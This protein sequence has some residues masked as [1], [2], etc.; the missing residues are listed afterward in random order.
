[1][2]W[3]VNLT[4]TA[5][6]CISTIDSK[7]H[8]SIRI[9]MSSKVIDSIDRLKSTL[10]HEMCHA[11]TFLIDKDDKPD[12]G[13]NFKKWGRKVTKIYPEIT[14]STTHTYEINYKYKYKCTGCEKIYG[15]FSKSIDCT[16]SSCG[17]CKSKLILLGDNQRTPNNYN[18][19]IKEKFSL[20]K[21]KF[22]N[23]SRSEILK[24]L[25]EDYRKMK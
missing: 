2:S 25:A 16:K 12:H 23:A 19:F 7:K 17:G 1:L 13:I 14:V 8:R 18:Q 15:R 6:R 20:K 3:S 10:V 11:A 9:E 5:G 4:K 21:K 24:L 22:P